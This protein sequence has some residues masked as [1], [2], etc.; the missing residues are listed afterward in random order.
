MLSLRRTISLQQYILGRPSNRA[1]I[2]WKG[3]VLAGISVEVVELKRE[4]GPALSDSS[5][6]FGDG[7]GR[8][9]TVRAAWLTTWTKSL[10]RDP[11]SPYRDRKERSEIRNQIREWQTGR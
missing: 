10:N 6:I 7:D 11:Q 5:I 1:V 9:K 3:K 4:C 2:C 8:L